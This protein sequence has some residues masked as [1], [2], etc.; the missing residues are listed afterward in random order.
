MK[1][2]V[3]A[4]S[5]VKTYRSGRSSVQA[6]R[7]VSLSIAPGEC[8][9]VVGE[10]GSGKSTVARLLLALDKPDSG[11]IV[12]NGVPLTG[13]KGEKL[14]QM[15]RHVQAVF[16]DPAS[17]FNERLPIWRSVVEPL[18]C[19]PDA[20]PPFGADRA[21]SRKELAALL[22][23]QAGLDS[24]YADRYPQELSGGQRQRAAIAR[25]IAIGPS[26]L[27]CDEPTSS[28]DVTLQKKVL[29]LLK[30]LQRELGMSILFISHDIAAAASISDRLLVMKDGLAVDEFPV[31]DIRL[32]GRHP[33]TRQLV[34]AVH[35]EEAFT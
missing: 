16:Q 27:V 34:S 22:L 32:A 3:E 18:D 10:S 11:E 7:G 9:G 1:P 15:R 12:L 35:G 30:Q 2:I 21:D 24:G 31:R 14:R 28:L 20:E 5:L 25:G 26:L 4:A 19:F 29:R 33:Y 13:L 23:E 6:L 8:L 17:A